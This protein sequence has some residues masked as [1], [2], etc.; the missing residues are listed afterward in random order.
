MRASSKFVRVY[1][2]KGMQAKVIIHKDLYTN[3]KFAKVF[4]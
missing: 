4:V 2:Q 1:I 3:S